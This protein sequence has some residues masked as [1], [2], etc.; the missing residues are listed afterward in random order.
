[1]HERLLA[2][3]DVHGSFDPF[4]EMIEQKIRLRKDDKLVLLGDYIDRGYR[5]REVIDYIIDLQLQGYDIVPLKGNHESMLLDS[6]ESEQS[7]YNWF[8]NGGYETLNSFG[9]E[10]VKELDIRY[11]KFFRSLQYY[12]IEDKFIFVHAGFNDDIA[13]PF[14]DKFEMIWS[15]RE[16]Y[17]NPV[18]AGK[19][20][21]HGHTPIP[22]S[23][24]REEVMSHKGVIN[25][26][27][28]CVYDEWGGYGHLSAIEL[29]TMELFS[30]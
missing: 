23:V 26:D 7:L 10:S 25:I 28:G 29:F 4:C 2:I 1:M 9:V 17:S 6:L 21:V 12:Y 15:R 20:I 16:H 30:V 11:L 24:C 19:I 27:T 8:M 18:F 5:S 3:G 22:L 13:D 14:I